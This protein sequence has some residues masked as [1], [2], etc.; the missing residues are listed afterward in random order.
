MVQSDPLDHV[1]NDLH[2]MID[3][4]Q[5]TEDLVAID[6]LPS[7][8]AGRGGAPLVSRSGGVFRQLAPQHITRGQAADGGRHHAPP[9]HS[10]APLPPEPL[11][12][13]DRLLPMANVA[14]LMA[15]E[16]PKES[17]AKIAKDAK[18]L[19]QEMVSEFICFITAEANDFSIQE[20]RKAISPEDFIR[21]FESLG[22]CVAQSA[23]GTSAAHSL[24][25]AR[26]LILGG[27]T[28][29][30]TPRRT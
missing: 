19:M 17:Q 21:S 9:R 30:R 26:T 22:K 28:F 8:E 16:L 15:S 4:G 10:T 14:R 2:G 6:E 3:C 29:P 27:Q 7:M 11:A 18:M 5:W 12:P 1:I 24:S 13:Q 25:R 23:L 20:N